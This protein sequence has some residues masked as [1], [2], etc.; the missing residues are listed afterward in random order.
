MDMRRLYPLLLVAIILAP[1]PLVHAQGSDLSCE[2]RVE[3]AAALIDVR[4]VAGALDASLDGPI[5]GPADTTGALG[6]AVSN[7]SNAVSDIEA[8]MFANG[9]DPQLKAAA[10]MLFMERSVIEY[11]NDLVDK[12]LYIDFELYDTY[13]LQVISQLLFLELEPMYDEQTA[14]EIRQVYTD[15]DSA[16]DRRADPQ[17]VVTLVATLGPLVADI[18]APISDEC[19]YLAEYKLDKEQLAL[20]RIADV[21]AMLEQAKN[22]YATDPDAALELVR[23]AYENS[24][25]PIKDGLVMVDRAE[26]GE[27]IERSLRD[28]LVDAI[29]AGESTVPQM[30]D[31]TVADLGLAE[32]AIPEFGVLTIAVLVAAIASIV[33]VSRHS[34]IFVPAR[35]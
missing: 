25:G 5:A 31:D 4:G 17:T 19:D 7:L 28:E 2:Q 14:H 15:I 18:N 11:E 12:D 6:N 9:I 10:V 27:S 23:L 20:D 3:A 16:Y 1:V 29:R 24:Y 32:Q 33:L 22:A 13:A 30:I 8:S 21:R 35:I 34:G 26:L